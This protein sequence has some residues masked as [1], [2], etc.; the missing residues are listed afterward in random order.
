MKTEIRDSLRNRGYAGRQAKNL[1]ECDDTYNGVSDRWSQNIQ[2]AAK[3]LDEANWGEA[4]YYTQW[5]SGATLWRMY[6]SAVCV[7]VD[8]KIDW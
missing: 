1:R 2:R 5:T 4:E 7:G 8:G 3:S 6:G